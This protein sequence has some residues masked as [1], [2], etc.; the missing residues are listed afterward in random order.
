LL[1]IITK[2]AKNMEEIRRKLQNIE[3][4]VN[5][6]TLAVLDILKEEFSIKPPDEHT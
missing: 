2:S 3:N 6:N 1:K 4:I 5:T